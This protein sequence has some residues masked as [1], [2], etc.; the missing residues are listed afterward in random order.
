[1]SRDFTLGANTLYIADTN[2]H[3]I[4]AFDLDTKKS[5]TLNIRM[6]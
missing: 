4:V 5:T 6:P 1:M 2:H 3:R